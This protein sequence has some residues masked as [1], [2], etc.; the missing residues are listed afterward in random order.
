[1]T[2]SGGVYLLPVIVLWCIMFVS[3]L[4]LYPVSYVRCNAVEARETFCGHSRLK[5]VRVFLT[6]FCEN[7]L[8][9]G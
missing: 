4:R 5:M 2:G 7:V 8:Y 6:D 3:L 9:I 1:M